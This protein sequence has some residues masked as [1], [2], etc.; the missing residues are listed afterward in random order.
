MSGAATASAG[1]IRARREAIYSDGFVLAESGE[2]VDVAPEGLTRVATDG[3]AAFAVVEGAQRTLEVGIGLGLGT[4]ALCE[5]LL[6]VGDPR[7]HHTV[8]D[9]FDFR[10]DA[11][12]RTVREAGAE[13][14]V[15]RLREPSQTALPRLWAEGERFDLA[16]VDGGHRFDEVFLDLV[17]C[18]HLVRPGGAIVIDDLWLPAVRAAVSYLEGNLGYALEP[19]ALPDGFRRRRGRPGRMGWSGRVAVLRRPAQ[20]IDRRWNAFTPFGP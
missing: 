17:F 5:A 12:Q 18:D 6:A 16:L 20:P 13:G 10:G 1:T 14:I 2:R 3:I 11:G 15:E 8:V 7:P 4:L 19:A 9:P